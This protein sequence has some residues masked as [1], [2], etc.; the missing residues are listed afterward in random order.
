MK[1]RPDGSAAGALPIVNFVGL[2]FVLLVVK[3]AWVVSHLEFSR[4]GRAEPIASMGWSARSVVAGRC[5]ER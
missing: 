1:K 2:R 3:D 4:P 5:R